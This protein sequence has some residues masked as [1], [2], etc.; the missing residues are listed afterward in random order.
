MNILNKHRDRLFL[1][2][3]LFCFLEKQF[4]LIVL[5]FHLNSVPTPIFLSRISSTKC[6]MYVF[7]VVNYFERTIY[8]CKML[9]QESVAAF[10][11]IN[12]WTKF[13]R[14][15]TLKCIASTYHDVFNK[16][17]A[18]MFL[19]TFE[20]PK[21]DWVTN[22]L[23]SRNIL[24]Y[25]KIEILR[26]RFCNLWYIRQI[27]PAIILLAFFKYLGR[28]LFCKTD[29]LTFNSTICGIKSEKVSIVKSNFT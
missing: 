23:F 19:W 12:L 26:I 29:I 14:W 1:F 21:Q 10:F 5:L 2:V 8:F 22:K 6:P 20:G 9:L 25:I 16:K 4:N 27:I 17:V 24:Q 3:F 18:F 15:L 7:I 28:K 11:I 13:G